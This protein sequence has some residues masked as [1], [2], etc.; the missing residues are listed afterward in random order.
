MTILLLYLDELLA[1]LYLFGIQFI[2]LMQLTENTN[3]YTVLLER[4]I[5]NLLLRAGPIGSFSFFL[6]DNN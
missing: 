6:L 2:N 4:L 5:D 1:Y 3:G